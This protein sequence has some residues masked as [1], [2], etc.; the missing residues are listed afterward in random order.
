MVNQIQKS[1]IKALIKDE[2]W[3]SILAF[4]QE[5]IEKHQGENVIGTTEFETLKL[6]FMKE[7]RI[8]GLK[9]FFDQLERH[10]FES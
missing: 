9:D 6:V 5:T 1:Q 8:Q 7:G 3:E 10:G 4:L 2:K